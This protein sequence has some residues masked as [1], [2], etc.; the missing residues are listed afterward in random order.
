[1]QGLAVAFAVAFPRGFQ[2]KNGAQEDYAMD[3]W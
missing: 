1:M 2:L 3:N